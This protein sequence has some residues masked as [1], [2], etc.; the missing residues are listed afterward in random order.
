VTLPA[1]LALAAAVLA[2]VAGPAAG[3]GLRAGAAEADVTP[4]VGVPLAGYGARLR[5]GL[6]DLDPRNDHVLF[7]PSTGVRD[8]IEAG[9]LALEAGGEAVVLLAVDAIGVEAALV[10]DVARAARERGVPLAADRLLVAA[11]HTHSGPGALSRRLLWQ[12]AAC[13]RFS[14]RVHRR[15]VAAL[16][17]VV[18][19]AWADRR[20]AALGHATARVPG[21]TRN[22]RADDSTLVGPDD[23]DPTLRVLRVDDRASGAP[24]AVVLNFAVHPTC[25]GADDL[26]LSADVAG[27]IRRTAAAALGCPVLFTNGAE[28][29][30]APR[31]GGEAGLERL[32]RVVGRAAAELAADVATGPAGV[33]LAAVERDLGPLVLHPG[34]GSGGGG[35]LPALEAVVRL[36]RRLGPRLREPVLSTRFR[37]AALRLGGLVLLFVPGEPITAVGAELGALAR[38]A[39]FAEAWVVGLANGHMG[40]VASRAEYGEGGYEAWMTFYGPDTAGRVREAFGEALAPL[41]P[42]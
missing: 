36:V 1:R 37:Y 7:E 8:P 9:A 16:A 18:A 35:D 13:D 21:V 23:V 25:L 32:G 5:R 19:A 10:D 15:F 26:E 20:P 30:V 22:R 33:R 41:M 31:P 17:D 28:G 40:Y 12:V 27:A 42:Y 38:D 11:S 2:A 3:G 14:R 34:L 29:D 39:G 24:I 4:A 6:P